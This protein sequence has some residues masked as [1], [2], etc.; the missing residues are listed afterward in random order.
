MAQLL[1]E[2]ERF[3]AEVRPWNANQRAANKLLAALDPEATSIAKSHLAQIEEEDRA[4]REREDKVQNTIFHND[5]IDELNVLDSNLLRPEYR[6]SEG[7]YVTELSA[8][9]KTAESLIDGGQADSALE[10]LEPRIKTVKSRGIILSVDCMRFSL[11]SAP[12]GSQPA[13]SPKISR[14]GR[15]ISISLRRPISPS[16]CREPTVAG[17]TISHSR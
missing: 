17:S 10:M 7:N 12:G 3:Y 4:L 13:R 5:W 1:R 14:G 6:E 8:V 9:I 2:A 11:A 15:A 16:T